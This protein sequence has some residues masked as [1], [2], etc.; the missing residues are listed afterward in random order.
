MPILRIPPPIRKI[1]IE[2]HSFCNR[3]CKWCSNSIYERNFYLEMTDKIFT[4]IID[5]LAIWEFSRP[6]SLMRYNEPLYNGELLKKRIK[7]I[8]E[9]LP[10]AKICVNTNGDY[11]VDGYDLDYITIMDYDNIKEEM[12]DEKIGL[13]IMK[14]KNI[15]D[16][17][18]ILTNLSSKRTERCME[19]TYTAAIDYLGNITYCCHMRYEC[20]KHKPY[21]F[22][23]V[24]KD[25]ITDSYYSKRA[26]EFRERCKN[27]DFPDVCKTCNTTPGRFSRKSYSFCSDYDDFNYEK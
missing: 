21:F 22:G 27:M 5:E 25:T 13:R 9:K 10:N 23:N 1:D 3:K 19:P 7:E 17:A 24:S 15:G 20:D 14:L 11:S 26:T 4:K 8:R 18:G 12:C 6:I 16:R 2:I